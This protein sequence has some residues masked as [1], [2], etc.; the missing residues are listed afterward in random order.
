MIHQM[1]GEFEK[2]E[3]LYKRSLDIS[4]KLGD[5][6]GTAASLH[7]LG[8]IYEELGGYKEAEKWYIKSLDIK[9][10][11]GDKHGIAQSLHHLGIIRE[12]QGEYKE[13][14]ENYVDSI[15][16]FLQVGSP[17]VKDVVRDFKNMKKNI[18]EERFD[19]Y[20]KSISSK[21]FH[22]MPQSLMI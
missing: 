18:G 16:I 15:T 9:R 13:A 6:K 4:E 22:N 12:A 11:L 7:Q 20:W 17:D 1:R 19:E 14:I 8:T 3:E 21:K 5:K 10:S 2:A